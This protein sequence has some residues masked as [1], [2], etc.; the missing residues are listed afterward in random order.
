MINL[1]H[2]NKRPHC[3]CG[4]DDTFATLMTIVFGWFVFE[5]ILWT[6]V[7]TTVAWQ[8]KVPHFDGYLFGFYFWLDLLA[9]LSMLLYIPIVVQGDVVNAPL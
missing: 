7:G 6:I 3:K 9:A 5:I 1:Q 2:T 8:G 4:A